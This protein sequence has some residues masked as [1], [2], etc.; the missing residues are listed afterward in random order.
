VLVVDKPAGATS[1][2]VVRRVQR[3]LGGRKAGH[4]G[5]LDP[6]ATGVLPICVGEATKVAG[7]L[8]A[9]DKAY[10][11][12]G[13]LGVETDT[14]DTTGTVTA[15]GEPGD[16]TREAL[17]QVLA[18]LRGP[19]LQTPPAYSAVRKDG[20][21]AYERARRGEAVELEPRPIEVLELEL[22]DWRPPRFEIRLECSKGTYVRSLV[23]DIGQRLGCGGAL[24]ALRRTRS[25][26][27]TIE[28]AV[29]LDQLEERGV[30]GAI[31]GLDEALSFLPSVEVDGAAAARLRQGQVVT[32][33]SARLGRLRGGASPLPS[34]PSAPLVRLI[35]EGKLVALGEQRED[36]L[37]PKRVFNEEH[38]AHRR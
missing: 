28:Q 18:G 27:F 2:D 35:C 6:M 29:P 26:P 5:T 11:G 19:Q 15:R 12:T 13:E 3:L 17:E 32:R 36:R 23:A 14:L 1:F 10:L 16:V 8:T 30:E 22:V 31:L 20:E 24:A 21:R 25:G 37:W 9:G 38:A 34:A 4:T 7:L 33:G